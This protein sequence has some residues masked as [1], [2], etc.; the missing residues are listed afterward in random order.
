MSA[1]VE[2][3]IHIYGYFALFPLISFIFFWFIA[4]IWYKD[5]K[6]STK[7]AMDLTTFLLFGAVSSMLDVIF[8]ISFGGF[9]FV[10]L[11]FLVAAGLVGNY[12]NRLHG[13]VDIKKL[14][15]IIWR[16]GFLLLSCVYFLLL[17]IG[18]VNQ[19]LK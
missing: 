1:I 9:W 14:I 6:K 17:I 18:I 4:F 13:A 10:L 5:K 12:Q 16:I 19:M 2:W 8:R 7:W 11:I 15:K 3:L